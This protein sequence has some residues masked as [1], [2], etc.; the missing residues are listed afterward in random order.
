MAA[1]DRHAPGGAANC[2]PMAPLAR[3]ED[4]ANCLRQAPPAQCIAASN[5]A[6]PRTCAGCGA[7]ADV[8]LSVGAGIDK[9]ESSDQEGKRI[10][11]RPDSKSG[12]G[13]PV[14]GSSP[15]PSAFSK[16]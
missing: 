7:G 6:P 8:G 9:L 16:G 5:P 12:A 2:Y 11:K 4:P 15:L 10:G 1:I 14:G 3:D 13:K